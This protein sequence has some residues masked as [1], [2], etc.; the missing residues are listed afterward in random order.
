MKAAYCNGD[1]VYREGDKTEPQLFKRLDWR[2]SQGGDVRKQRKDRVVKRSVRD[3]FETAEE[4]LSTKA[5]HE[6]VFLPL[7]VG[8]RRG[9]QVSKGA[10]SGPIMV[11]QASGFAV[12]RLGVD[13]IS[14]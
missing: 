1:A 13:G 10:T 3:N 12:C 5:R 4:C 7:Q 8:E 14:G 2:G 6:F 11:I 9:C